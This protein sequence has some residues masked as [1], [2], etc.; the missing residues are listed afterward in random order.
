MEWYY[1]DNG[2]RAGPIDQAEFD[3]LVQTGKIRGNTLIWREGMANWVSYRETHGAGALAPPN[4]SAAAV[5]AGGGG[6]APMEVV[7][8]ECKGLFPRENTIQYGAAYIC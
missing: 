8:T 4:P 7:C 3:R 1:V 5:S 2:Q 6:A